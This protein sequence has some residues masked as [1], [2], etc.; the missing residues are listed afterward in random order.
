MAEGE[1]KVVE[2]SLGNMAGISFLFRNDLHFLHHNIKG[3]NFKEAH[4]M[5]SEYYDKALENMDYFAEHSLMKEKGDES[6]KNFSTVHTWSIYDT[7]EPIEGSRMEIDEAFEL[8]IENGNNYLDALELCRD[9]CEKEGWDDIV[10]D[11]DDI[12]SYWALEIEYKAK[13]IVS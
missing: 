7:W 4:D 12:H 11:I 5:F 6:F 9:Y 10:S 13:S 2:F 1:G 3:I 8:F